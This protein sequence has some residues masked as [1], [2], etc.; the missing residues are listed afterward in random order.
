MLVSAE[1]LEFFNTLFL[2]IGLALSMLQW[3]EYSRRDQSCFFERSQFLTIV[4]TTSMTWD[5]AMIARNGGW[6]LKNSMS[7]GA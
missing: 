1:L 5:C 6:G 4:F 2:S 7:K 3:T